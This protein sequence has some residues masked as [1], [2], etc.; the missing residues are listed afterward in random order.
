MQGLMLNQA[1][2]KIEW[3]GL[4]FEHVLEAE[5]VVIG[6][7]LYSGR[8]AILQILGCKPAG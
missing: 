4:N 8:G 5:Q 7:C 2:L 1:E 6:G 3:A